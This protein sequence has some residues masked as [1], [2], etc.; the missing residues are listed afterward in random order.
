MYTGI[1]K[2]ASSKLRQ[3]TKFNF[4]TFHLGHLRLR[5]H[6]DAV[7]ANVEVVCPPSQ[8][9]SLLLAVVLPSDYVLI[10]IPTL[11]RCHWIQ[12]EHSQV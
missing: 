1:V 8:P 2:L 9:L 3:K 12:L 11:P 6:L 5:H 4:Y 7:P 10:Q